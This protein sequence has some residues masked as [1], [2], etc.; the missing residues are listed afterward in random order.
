MTESIEVGGHFTTCKVDKWNPDQVEWAK[1]KMGV[2]EP[3]G[4]QL[5]AL[6]PPVDTVYSEKNVL[7]TLGLGRM[8]NFLI[9]TGSLVGFTATTTGLAVGDSATVAW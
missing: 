6:L 2:D 4:F 8:T 9:G 1:A 3:K 7:T 5:R